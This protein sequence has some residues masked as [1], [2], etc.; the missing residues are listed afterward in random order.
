MI[1]QYVNN[2]CVGHYDLKWL[3]KSLTEIC[4]FE[5]K[6]VFR[7][8]GYGE[9]MLINAFTS[10]KTPCAIA[11]VRVDNT[12]WCKTNLKVG[13]RI[14]HRIIKNSGDLYLFLKSKQFEYPRGDDGSL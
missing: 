4:K 1:Y 5:I 7:N 10:I 3:N 13:F 6:P 11:T 12:N 14:I 8:R 9:I 2:E